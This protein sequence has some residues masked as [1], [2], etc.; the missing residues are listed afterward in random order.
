[1]SKKRKIVI[2]LLCG[3]CIGMIV[4]ISSNC[5]SRYSEEEHAERIKKLV[6]KRYF[7]G[8]S[9]YDSY[10][11]YP[12]YDESD[13]LKYFLVEF[14]PSGFLYVRINAM[15]LN[16]LFLSSMYTRCNSERVKWRRFTIAEN[17]Y[18]DG[19]ISVDERLYEKDEDGND[20]YRE[21]SH[22]KAAGIDNEKRYLLGITQA[23]S[24]HSGLIPAVKRDGRYLD[25]VSMEEFVYHPY[26]NDYIIS[27]ESCLSSSNAPYLDLGKS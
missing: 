17:A 25:L 22:F 10:D 27:M 20:I 14:S 21:C 19:V 26:V 3:I 16:W 18:Q 8:Q 9:K 13:E 11:I 23:D 2:I 5:S 24:H 1:M 15:N 7:S 12:V 6:E 4:F